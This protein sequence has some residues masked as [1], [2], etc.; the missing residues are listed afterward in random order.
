MCTKN[1]TTFQK[2]N[3]ANRRKCDLPEANLDRFRAYF[4]RALS[5]TKANKRSK[6]KSA[7]TLSSLFF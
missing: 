7:E 2:E 1:E 6:L 3:F 5:L 4:S